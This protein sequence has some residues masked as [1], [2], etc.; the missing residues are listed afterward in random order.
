MGTRLCLVSKLELEVVPVAKGA[1]GSSLKS[2]L[3]Y[4]KWVKVVLFTTNDFL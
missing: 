1:T 3:T 2:V 4:P